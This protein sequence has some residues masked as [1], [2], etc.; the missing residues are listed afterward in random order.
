MGAPIGN[1]NG[2]KNRPFTEAI[3]RALLANN[4]KKLRA[5]ADRLVKEAERGKFDI[6][7]IREVLD[8]V[9]GKTRQHI[10]HTGLN[11]GPIEIEVGKRERA[12]RVAFLLN[13]G[14]DAANDNQAHVAKE[15]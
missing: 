9:D 12:R 5:I 14:V 1:Q 7:V 4:G 15:A 2:I 10:E 13:A 6:A 11:D 3:Q 8:R